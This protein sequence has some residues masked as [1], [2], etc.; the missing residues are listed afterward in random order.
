MR[1][2]L[3][4]ILP[5]HYCHV[6]FDTRAQMRKQD[7]D[8]MLAAR[9]DGEQT[10]EKANKREGERTS[11]RASDRIRPQKPLMSNRNVC[12]CCFSAVVACFCCYCYIATAAVAV[13]ANVNVKVSLLIFRY[14]YIYPI[15]SDSLH[16][17]HS[18]CAVYRA[19]NFSN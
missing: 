14:I 5:L 13:A 2:I 11:K 18:N 1:C 16:T 15:Q 6:F 3:D 7:Q 19:R 12:A 17:I 10:S 9:R 8:R 4:L